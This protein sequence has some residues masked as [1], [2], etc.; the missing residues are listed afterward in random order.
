MPFEPWLVPPPQWHSAPW[1]GATHSIYHFRVC[2]RLVKVSSWDL[3]PCKCV[4]TKEASDLIHESYS[5]KVYHV[6]MKDKGRQLVIK[7]LWRCPNLQ[8][9]AMY[10]LL[11]SDQ[12]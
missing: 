9:S 12:R 3:V 2:P 10:L 8:V 1:T 11:S 7:V 5:G 4:V 6:T